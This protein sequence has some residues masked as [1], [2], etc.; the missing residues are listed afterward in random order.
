MVAVFGTM[1][2]DGLRDGTGISYG[3]AAALVA[4]LILALD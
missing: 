1:V 3:A 2:A 4:L